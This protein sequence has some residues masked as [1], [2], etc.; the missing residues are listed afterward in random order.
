MAAWHK[1]SSNQ[2]THTHTHT[3]THACT[4]SKFRVHHHDTHLRLDIA[5]LAACEVILIQGHL[6]RGGKGN[7]PPD[8]QNSKMSQHGLNGDIHPLWSKINNSGLHQHLCGTLPFFSTVPAACQHPIPAQSKNNITQF[9]LQ[10]CTGAAAQILFHNT[11]YISS[12]T[13]YSYLVQ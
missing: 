1:F 4:H 3:N 2:D 8:T 10:Q 7:Q 6:Q 13:W 12:S 5:Q 11:L 9:L